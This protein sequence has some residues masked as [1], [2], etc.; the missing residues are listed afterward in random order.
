MKDLN[1]KL[2]QLLSAQKISSLKTSDIHANQLT[3]DT[4]SDNDN[5]SKI[6][7]KTSV[8]PLFGHYRYDCSFL[9]HDNSVNLPTLPT[10]LPPIGVFW[11][12]ENCH[13]PKGRSAMAVTQV[14]RD[15]FFSGYR[16]AEFIVVC[17]VQKES[18]QVMQELNDAQVNLIH[19]AA[20]C[21]NAADEKLKQSIRRFADIHGSPAAI[22]LISGDIDFAADLSDLRYRKKIHVILLHNKSTSEALI[23]CA[24]EH[25]D[26]MDLMEPLPSRPLL[27][28]SEYYDLIVN[29]LPEDKDVVVIKRRLQKLS[30][31]CGGRVIGIQFKTAIVRFSSETSA[32]RAQKRMDG[33]YV[34]D[35]KISVRFHKETG[36]S[37]NK[38]QGNS[39]TRNRAISESEIIANSSRQMY[40]AS[41][42]I[43][44]ARTLQ[45]PHYQSSSPVVGPYTTWAGVPCAPV[46]ISSGMIQQPPII[47]ARPYSSNSDVTFNRT[48][49]ELTRVQSPLIWQVAGSQQFNHLWEDQYKVEKTKLSSKRIHAPQARDNSAAN[50]TISRT[51]E[52]LRPIRG[53]HNSFIHA[54]E[55]AVHSQTNTF[56]R[57][58][59]S[60]MYESQIHERNNQWNGQNQHSVFIRNTRTPSPYEGTMIRVINQ[61]NNHFSPYHQNDAE[62]E[63]VEKF[64]HPINRNGNGTSN[65]S[66]TP[67]E[68][69]VSNLDQNIDPKEM[70]HILSSIFMEHVTVLH[71][72]IFMQSDGNYAASVKVASL[73]D[74]QYAISQLHRRKIGYKRILI[75][76]AHTGGPNPQLIRAQIVMLLQEVPGHK[77]PLF[78]FREMYESRFMISI[79]ISELYKMKDVCIV[80]EDASGRMVSLNPDHRNTPSPCF[81]T[82]T[83][84]GYVEL[85]Y[86]IKHTS[87]PWSDKGWAEQEM[88]SLPNV[89]VSLKLLAPRIQQLLT[90]H[91][92]SLP[93]PSLP[94]CYAAE[95][96]EHLK[97]IE[98][99]VPLEH[100]VSCL[101]FVQLKQG[102][103]SVKYLSWALDK[104][105]DES[106][107]ENKCVSP[108]LANQLALFS[109]ELV[110]LLKTAP[111]CQLPFNRFIPAYH[112]HFGRQCRVADYGFTKLI[113]LLEALTHTVQ[114]MGEGN[115]RVVTL[116]HR[117]QV[118]RFTSDL[119]R[120]LKSKASK[121]VTLS[122]FPN[123][124]SRVIAKPWDIVDYGVCEIEDI[125]SEVSENTVVMT[126]IS[127]GDKMIA[128]PKREQTAEEIERTKQFAFEVVELLRHV[129]QC[130]MLFNK[131]VPS[132]HHHF[133]HQCRVS[134]YGFTKLIEL[135][136]AIPDVVKIEDGSNG[137]RQISLTEKEG[138]RVLSEQ[139]SK[140]VAHTKSGLSVSNIVQNFLRQFGYALRP[141]LFGCNSV[142]QLMQ[143]LDDSVKII[144]LATGPVI[145]AIDKSHLQQLALQCRRVLMD[146]PQ[147]KTPV[148]EFRQQYSQYYSKICNIEELKKD[149]S[150]V[151][152][153]TTINEEN[154][155][156]LTPL[157]CFACNLYRVMMSCGGQLNLSRFEAAY[158]AVNGSAC[159]AAQYGFP[160]LTALLQALPC[161]VILKDTRK[162]KRKKKV[163][164]LNKKL[165]AVGIALPVMYA[166][167]SSYHDTDSSNE[168]FE[169]DS[170][171]RIN[172]SSNASTLE[173]HGKWITHVINGHNSWKQDEDNHFWTQDCEKH[174]KVLTYS[175]ERSNNWPLFENNNGDFL[176]NL[177]HTPTIIQNDFPAPPPKP[178]SPPE[179]DI[180][181]DNQWKSSVWIAPTK[182]LYSQDERVT[183]VEVPP[184]TLPSWNQISEDDTLNLLSPTK[185]LLPAAA[186][187]LN[188]RT[189]PYF[190]NKHNLVV[191]PHP[192]ELPLPSLSLTPKKNV[193]SESITVVQ[194]CIG[195]QD[196]N[197]NNISEVNNTGNFE[198]ENNVDN[199]KNEILNTPTK[200]LFTG[201]RRLAAQFN[202]PLQS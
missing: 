158:L 25:Y 139:I 172:A 134:D 68:L 83:Q 200:P 47:V 92:G 59:P 41:A 131:F 115:K 189:S 166:S 33:E 48:Y 194:D 100:L 52:C 152:Q 93:L 151:V 114:V 199:K 15:K 57:R 84:E 54:S 165:A 58:S 34:F 97:V 56:K 162:D 122:E 113:D 135:F 171:S 82:P 125:L 192:S 183:N 9:H 80:T 120:V 81:S 178:D 43:A 126:T 176:K 14:I 128:I 96:K 144:D 35:S 79:S 111:H 123:V 132:Y 89:N 99:G 105:H 118:R 124:Y 104:D 179:V 188:P 202:Q 138:L 90:M 71:V 137:E 72:S 67:I 87:K 76:Y 1:E 66:Y 20:T 177:I 150:H 64:F 108:P 155:I 160:T 103:G 119:L 6:E 19:V 32:R 63:E 10:Y 49:N 157:H 163:I 121:Q 182:I 3:Y 78:K 88:A 110:D 98:N 45:V 2:L 146:Q 94:N 169:S 187:P 148:K 196:V 62:N 17:D 69:Q 197:S 127:G 167:G 44:G 112:H 24:N 133:G 42:S 22:I 51:P 55:W 13:V 117:A 75:S 11:D 101:S 130:K 143:K 159:R 7:S 8:S 70:K 141:E 21:K 73:P 36:N 65:G 53:A 140:L 153:F 161:T 186:N 201:K 106:H 164:Y 37:N 60:P 91:N 29:N 168:S 181:T 185:N 95:F 26:F 195:K 175:E 102:I 86:C 154:F 4:G 40:S 109:R 28:I 190:S 18:N 74:A 23:L 136:E 156:E 145:V 85:P 31:N 39:I 12:I 107:E 30:D 174:W 38:S 173:E 129:P 198:K 50:G 149:L 170:S 191:A 142:L 61:Q 77:L 5:A 184:L 27:K 180:R 16:E 193:S 46:S 116:S 147:Y